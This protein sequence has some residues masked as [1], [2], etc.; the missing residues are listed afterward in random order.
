[1]SAIFNMGLSM[2]VIRLR[3]I[4]KGTAVLAVSAALLSACTD[5]RP[6][7]LVA[8]AKE[9]LAKKDYPAASIQLKNALKQKDSGE[10][11]Y[12]LGTTSIGMG[13]Y[14]A[15]Q[16]QLRQA[17]ESKY[18]VDAIYPELS[19][20]ML[21]LGEHKKL[22]SEFENVR[23]SDGERQASIKS[24]IGEA[25]LAL[26]QPRQAQEAF[27][28]ALAS[29]AGYPRARA[30]E[31]RNIATAG[32]VAGA[33]AIANDIL[34]KNPDFPSALALKADLLASQ[35]K[36]EEAVTILTT[37]VKVMPYNG[38]A[39][40]AL[41]SLL[42]AGGKFDLANGAITDMKKNLPRDIRGKYLEA[43]LAFRQNEPAKA[44]DAVLQV[45]NAIPD[46]GPSLL[47][48]GA[49]EYQ[50]GSLSTAADY[51]RKVIAKFPNNLYARNLLVATYLRQGQPGKAEDALA[52]AISL[53]PN[54]PTVLRAAGE[55][56]VANN[57]LKDAAKYYDR[58]LALEKDNSALKTRLAQIRLASG[59]TDRAL[60]D[61]E[62]TS[63]LD[64]TQYQSDLALIST[65]VTRKEYDKA[66]AAVATLEQK[67]PN[68][69]T[70]YSIKGAVYLAK[71]DA[72]SARVHL[73]KALS[74]QAN[75]L[76]AA[77]VLAGLDITDKNFAAATNRF[78]SI[79][80]K[81]PNNEGALL[82]L[83]Q[84]QASAKASRKEIIATFDRAIKAN[85]TSV[86]PRVA[87]ISFLNQ[88]RDTTATLAA[89]QAANAAIQ[90]EPRIL[91][92]LGLAQLAA[93]ETSQAIET[94]NKLASAQ[95]DSPLPQL[96]LAAASY[97][98]KQVDAPIQALR[99]ALAIKPDLL[100]AQRGI[101][102]LQIAAGKPEA[103]LKE[104]KAI[105]Q[106][107]PKE[108]IGFAMEGEVLESQKKPADAAKAYAEALK[109]QP[110][111]ELV[112]KQIQL[113]EAAGLSAEASAATAKWLKENPDDST[114]RFFLATTSMQNKNYKDAAQ[115]YKDILKKQPNH[116]ETLNNL[117]WILGEL[118]DSA[119]LS[120]AE[121]AYALAPTN[122]GVLDTYGWLL[123]NSDSGTRGI[124]LL[125]QAA[126]RAPQAVEIRVHLAKA[127]IKSGDKAGAKKELEAAAKYGE[128]SALKAEIE[129]L[130]RSL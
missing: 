22:V 79:L 55:V 103:A 70:T 72:K 50:L 8:S 81:E 46:Q 53:A 4:L 68:H 26:G 91:D 114:V 63:G 32:D 94:F 98:A 125:S 105:Q 122:A 74:V 102:A 85:P 30:G 97:A 39:R 24:D 29:V 43:L 66:L 31:G 127:L 11:R 62:S 19:K 2:N 27:S 58:A 38:Q 15:A 82:A 104:A 89:A 7:T 65:Y 117:A 17:L 25:Y 71:N 101:I 106:A 128:K 34:A 37:L 77:R 124:E 87:Q 44:R 108:A 21:A 16:V 18:P 67:L 75:Y 33:T 123:V 59:E 115:R 35:G 57:K 1:M 5:E 73:E 95:P 121:K 88:T 78:E 14:T 80:A 28:A 116:F 84:V 112:V 130:L 40:F 111:A 129:Q 86:A 109:R 36:T 99:K 118:K 12:L 93:G 47:L 61:L 119:A 52:P 56:A 64:K 42:I 69:P 113:L 107:R 49:A 51:L 126:T 76:P 96:R 54:D 45:L 92:A 3:M 6:D 9:Y 110:G 60:A 41:V 100:E 10:I 83:A 13:D 48:A 120:Y 23:I 20:V 90:N